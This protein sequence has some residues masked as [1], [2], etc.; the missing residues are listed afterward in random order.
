M[1]C[2][3][4]ASLLLASLLGPAC[5]NSAMQRYRCPSDEG[6]RVIYLPKDCRSQ[7]ATEIAV[8][9]DEI[10]AGVAAL[11]A[12]SA[13]VGVS[14][15]DDV[16]PLAEKLDQLTVLYRDTMVALCEKRQ[17]EPCSVDPEEVQRLQLQLTDK[18]LAARL[19]LDGARD[20]VRG[21]RGTLDEV[22]RDAIVVGVQARIRAATAELDA[23]SA[24]LSLR[25]GN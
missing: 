3:P 9:S 25:G 22:T 20:T 24:S 10:K 5:A 21:V 8:H 12:A 1:R 13:S 4:A 19:Q 16:V 6:V 7:Y 15:T 18:F 11:E 23:A 14:F 2:H 17:I